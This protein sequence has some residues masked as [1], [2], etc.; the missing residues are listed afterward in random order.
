VVGGYDG[1]E[2][3]NQTHLFSPESGQWQEKA[4]LQEKRGGLGLIS[5]TNNLYAIGGGWTD[6][7]T[8]NEKYDPATDTWTTF[9]SPFTHQWRNMGLTVL[10]TN[11][12]AVGGWDGTEEKFVDSVASYQFLFQLF[13]PLSN[14]GQ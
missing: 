3:F 10:D 9:E 7:L 5:A 4:P 13:L 6:P 12:Y 11:I 14:F 2:A 8:T 1:R